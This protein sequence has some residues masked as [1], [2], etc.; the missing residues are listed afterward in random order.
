[1]AAARTC[2]RYVAGLSPLIFGPEMMRIFG[3]Y[4]TLCFK[5]RIYCVL[6]VVNII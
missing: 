4:A 1:M 5:P 3:K 2:E 6:Y